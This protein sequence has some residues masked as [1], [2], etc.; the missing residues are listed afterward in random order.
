MSN[1]ITPREP[2]SGDAVVAPS[3]STPPMPVTTPTIPP[4]APPMATGVGGAPTGRPTGVTILAVLAIIG[5]VF[6]LFGGLA[7]LAGGA[8]LGATGAGGVGGFV[9]VMGIF[10][11]AMGILYA[12]AAY[13]LFKR[14]RWAWYLAM[15]GAA[16]GA[17]LALLNLAGGDVFSALVGLVLNGVVIWYLLNPDVQAWFGLN[18]TTPWKY[19]GRP[20]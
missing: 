14:Q 18:Y 16:L 17:V 10:L 6:A 13:G 5:A 20:A 2:T 15:A 19:R 3:T 12:A 7:S 4:P 8:I 9:A 11:I 1:P